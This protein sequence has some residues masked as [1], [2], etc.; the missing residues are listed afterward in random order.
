[1]ISYFRGGRGEGGG[2]K[3]TRSCSFQGRE[4]ETGLKK[5]KSNTGGDD[6]KRGSDL[7]I[8]VVLLEGVASRA[9]SVSS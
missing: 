8:I 7:A 9:G 3:E 6:V 5:G 2:E 1:V 4:G